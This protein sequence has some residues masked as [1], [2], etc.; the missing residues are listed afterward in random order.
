MYATST[1][2]ATKDYVPQQ[3]EFI[4]S[5]ETRTGDSQCLGIRFID[6]DV[7]DLVR[8]F[9]VR[10]SSVN[11]LV[12]VQPGRESMTVGIMDNDCKFGI[13]ASLLFS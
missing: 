3:T 13:H 9:S 7:R 2:A 4:F 5:P 10:L 1:H 6:N 12:R 11:P 8:S